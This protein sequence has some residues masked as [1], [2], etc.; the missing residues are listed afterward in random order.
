MIFRIRF[1]VALAPTGAIDRAATIHLAVDAVSSDA[2]PADANA[3]LNADTARAH[4]NTGCD[5]DT[6]C[7]GTHARNDAHTARAPALSRLPNTALRR[8]ICVTVN[9]GLSRRRNQH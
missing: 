1:P 9:G 7:T 2:V 5:A 3:R 6:G 8:A 4:A